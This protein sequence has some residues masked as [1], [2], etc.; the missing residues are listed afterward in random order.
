MATLTIPVDRI[1]ERARQASLRKGMLAA[2]RLLAAFLVGIPYALGWTVSKLWLGLTIA[3][4]AAGEG[5]RD[6]ARSRSARGGRR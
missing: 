1:S 3:W 2:A 6:A 5:W 4:V